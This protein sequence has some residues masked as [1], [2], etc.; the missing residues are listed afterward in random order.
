MKSARGE[1]DE[2]LSLLKK[3]AEK[4]ELLTIYDANNM[5]WLTNLARHYLY[6]T[7]I[8]L[9]INNTEEAEISLEL[10]DKYINKR[11]QNSALNFSDHVLLINLRD[12]LKAIL[13]Y[14]QLNSIAALE[15]F[16]LIIE[17]LSIKIKKGLDLE[18]SHHFLATAHFYAGSIENES[19]GKNSET[20]EHL[21]QIHQLLSPLKE[22]LHPEA[23][24]VLGRSYLLN[25]EQD[26]AL[27][28]I[29]LL[30]TRGYDFNTQRIINKR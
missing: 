15:E 23:L 12:L 2:A 28:I 30:E 21:T 3:S 11:L 9:A 25:D 26:K 5:T 16:N 20:S 1:F 10:A 4:A 29:E 14:Q 18:D 24:A 22:K 17:E 27:P 19:G 13:H 8:Y 6:I 7:K